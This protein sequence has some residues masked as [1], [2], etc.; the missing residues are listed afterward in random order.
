MSFANIGQHTNNLMDTATVTVADGESSSGALRL[1]E[2]ALFGLVMPA[3]WTS[4]SVSFDVSTDGSTYQH[5]YDEYGSEVTLGVEAG[6]SYGF[7][8]GFA[9]RFLAWKYVKVRSG[10]AGSFVNQSGA[11]RAITLLGRVM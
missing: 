7:S 6:K 10:V 1:D 5:L 9:S 3:A 8:A 2:Y 4:A 11:D